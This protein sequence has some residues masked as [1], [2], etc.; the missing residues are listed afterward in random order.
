MD[1][2]QAYVNGKV[3][4]F[5]LAFTQR[6]NLNL[7]PQQLDALVQETLANISAQEINTARALRLVLRH[8]CQ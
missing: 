6:L 4:Q 5:A 3:K 1:L 7:A 2:A 8:D